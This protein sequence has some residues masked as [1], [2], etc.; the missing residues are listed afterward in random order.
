MTE[1]L[2]FTSRA[3]IGTFY[4]TLEA[5]LAGSWMPPVSFLVTS[6]QKVEHYKWLGMAPAVR[7]WI[8]GRHPQGLRADAYSLE[9]LKFEAT[10]DL[11]VDD[12]NRDKTGQIMLR[13]REMAD[14]V[15]EHWEVLGSAALALGE[16]ALC[17][18]GQAFFSAA[19]VEGKSGTQTNLLTATEVPQLEV[20]SAT[21]PTPAEMAQAILGCIAYQ[22]GYKDD[23]GLP[24]NGQARNFLVQVPLGLYVPAIAAVS[25]PVIASASGTGAV[26]NLLIKAMNANALTVRVV[27]NPLLEWTENFV[28][29]RTDARAKPLIRQEEY[30][31]K[32]SAKAEGSEYE[33]DF[34]RHQYGIKASR[35]VGYGYWQ[36]AVK[37]TLSAAAS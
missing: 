5:G 6:Q 21:A 11:E 26:D 18:D 12:L 3:I 20:V 28:V 24:M 19:H 8:A 30:G 7:Q 17:Y 34:D 4:Q 29:L 13:V 10:L 23:Q 15:N 1:I 36:Y 31:V 2:K 14:R 32:M 22:Y 25:A 9:N 37:A 16:S 35:N 33:H 27:V